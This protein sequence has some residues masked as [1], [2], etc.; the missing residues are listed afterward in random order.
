MP[1]KIRLIACLASLALI[2]VPYGARGGASLKK[3]MRFGVEA[4]EHGLWREAVFRWERYLEERPDDARVRNNL[5]VGYESLGDFD[6]ARRQYEEALRLDPDRKEIREN[7]DD[8][9]QILDLLAARSAS[10]GETGE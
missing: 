1:G 9:R 7:Y 4:A 5:A 8:F 10:P 6:G 3:Q 2:L